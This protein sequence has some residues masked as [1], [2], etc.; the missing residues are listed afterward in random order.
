MDKLEEELVT[1]TLDLNEE[2]VNERT[3]AMQGNFIKNIMKAM[4]GNYSFPAEIRG[5]PTQIAAFAAALGKEKSFMKAFSQFGLDDPRTYKSRA[6]LDS[7]VRKFES[8]TKIKW[9][10]K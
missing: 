6:V 5:T 3:L 7:A 10:F 9:P 8:V 2:E 4:F 1:Q